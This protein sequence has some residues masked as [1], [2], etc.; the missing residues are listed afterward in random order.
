[1][2]LVNDNV[3]A[4]MVGRNP[5][6]TSRPSGLV[7]AAR[8]A[9]YLSRP[10]QKIVPGLVGLAFFAILAAGFANRSEEHLT[11]ESGLGYWLGIAGVAA[12]SL[13]LVY[14]LRKRMRW[15]R[16]FGSV[17]F[18]FR[19]H[20]LLGMIAPTLILYHSNFSLGSMNSNVA[21]FT[22]L[23][24]A[25]SGLIGRFFYGKVHLGMS[26]QKAIAMGIMADVEA[27]RGSIGMELPAASKLTTDLGAFG[28]YALQERTGFFAQLAAMPAIAFR[29]RIARTRILNEARQ[30]I[31]RE[32]KL[33]K[34]SR[35]VR[36]A[37]LSEVSQL[38]Q[39]YFAALKKASTLA[40]F[41]RL[42]ALWHVLHLPLFYLLV[43]AVIVHVVAV[44]LY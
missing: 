19:L 20:M 12:M 28:A 14:P 8:F 2:A 5:G 41:E 23:T 25:G 35:T 37:K 21:L 26:G 27:L 42:L 15:L 17:I 6:S 40:L 33:Q 9:H 7:L 22:M 11:P 31:F 39:L 34:W 36:N 30:E 13:L 24:V 32:A 4:G 10:I 44:H 38:L 18:W 1:M 29:A 16:S 3:K 43:V